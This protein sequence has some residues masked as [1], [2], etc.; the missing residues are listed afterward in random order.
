MTPAKRVGSDLRSNPLKSIKGR[1]GLTVR[2]FLIVA[3][4]QAWPAAFAGAERHREARG[5]EDGKVQQQR[6]E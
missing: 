1:A 4:L 3:G 2:V 6:N 5:E